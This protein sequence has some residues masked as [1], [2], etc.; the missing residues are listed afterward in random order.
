MLSSRRFGLDSSQDR[1][2]DHREGQNRLPSA[3][4][5]ARLAGAA[6]SSSARVKVFFP[7]GDPGI[8][9]DRVYPLTRTVAAPSVLR[10][11]IERLLDGPTGAERQ[12]GY[13]GW[14]SART[15]GALRSANLSRRRDR[16]PRPSARDPE[17]LELMRK[18]AAAR[19]AGPN[20]FAV[21]DGPAGRLLL[22]RKPKGVLRVAPAIATVTCLP[23]VGFDLAR[24]MLAPGK[25]QRGSS[26]PPM[27]RLTFGAMVEPCLS[28]RSENGASAARG[29]KN[30]T[31]GT[32][33]AVAAAT[34]EGGPAVD[35]DERPPFLFAWWGGPAI[36]RLR[37]VRAGD[38]RVPRGDSIS[39]S[40]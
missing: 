17:R 8:R 37:V 4:T 5:V 38:R 24:R 9:C 32:V 2:A 23:V 25:P 3:C 14:F 27:S 34:A 29:G 10:G 11:A 39:R 40:A 21:S 26:R 15:A 20:G 19:T 36:P 7:R 1:S 30:G 28:R 22:Q 13:G 12:R 6:T 31:A 33:R 16:F 18:C 35:G